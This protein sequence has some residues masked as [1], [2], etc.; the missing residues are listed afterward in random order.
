MSNLRIRFNYTGTAKSAWAIDNLSTPGANFPISYSWSGTI[1]SSTSGFPVT[2]TPQTT[3]TSYYTLQTTIAGCPGGQVQ[4]P[5]VVNPLPTFG[6][7]SQAPVCDGTNATFNLTGLTPSIPSTIKYSI[8]PGDTVTVIVS[9]V[10][11]NGNG[12]FTA[13]LTYADNGK[14]ITITSISNKAV[15]SNSLVCSV[16]PNISTT[17]TVLPL[18]TGTVA[19]ATAVCQND[20]SPNITFTGTGTGPFIFTYSINSGNPIT[21]S[22][23]NSLIL[24]VSTAIAGTFNYTLISVK[25]NTAQGCINTQTSSAIVT[26]NAKATVT[27]VADQLACPEGTISFTESATSSVAPTYTWQVSTD[28]G[29]SWNT[30]L[31]SDPDYSGMTTNTLTVKNITGGDTKDGYLYQANVVAS[32]ACAVPVAPAKLTIRNIW[33]GYTDQNWNNASNWSNNE[34]PSQSSCDS[35]IILNVANKPILSTGANGYVNHLKMRPGAKLT[36]TGNI[37]HIAGSITDDNMAIDATVGTIDLNGDKELYIPAQPRVMQTIAGHMFNTPYANNS[38]RLLNLNI[39]SPNNA[40]VA[41][42]SV[43]ND[44]LNITG[45]LSFGNLN[46]VTLH[47]GNNITLVSNAD[48]TARVAD[49]TSGNAANNNNTFDGWVEVERYVRIGLAGDQHPKAWEFLA[50]PTKGQ[51]TYQS[52]MENGNMASTGYGTQ[53]VSPFGSGF[54]AVPAIYPSMKYYKPGTNYDPSAPDWQ[55]IMDTKTSIFSQNGYMLFIRGDRSIPGPFDPPNQTRMRTKGEL[56]TYTQTVPTGTYQFTSVGNPYASAIDFGKVVRN[57]VDPFYTVW[58]S[59]LGG[60]YGYGAYDTYTTY[61]N[62]QTYESTD[63][64]PNVNIQSGQAFFVQTTNGAGTLT[65]NETSKTSGSNNYVFRGSAANNIQ[66]LRTNLYYLNA[67]GSTFRADGNVVQFGDKFNN[68]IDGMDGRK[69]FNSGPN[70]A[71]QKDKMYLVVERRQLPGKGDTIYMNLSGVRA[72]NYRFVFVAQGLQETGLQAFLED[73]YLNTL[74]PLNMGDTT[75][76]DFKIENVK[77]SYA[78]NRFDIVFKQAIILPPLIT[79]VEGTPKDKDIQVDW[80]VIHEKN[81][82]QYEVERSFD[83][84]QFAKVSTT[85]ALNKD[86]SSYNWNDQFVLPGTYYYRIKLVEKSGKVQ[87]SK[88][89]KVLIGNGKPLISIYP[90]PITNGIINLQFINQPAGKYGIRLMNQLGQIIVS[91][92]IVRMNGSNTE[93]IH[94]DYNLAHGVYQLQIFYP[95]GG[96]KVIKVI[97]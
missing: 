28:N 27:P 4:V 59:Y 13:P 21:S 42:I 68:R 49:I 92:Q 5:V 97:Y 60:L 95:D 37:L 20:A 58:I 18:P 79:S 17:L 41:P 1:L 90:N 9:N 45:T 26:V 96:M 30:I 78:Q 10:D 46:N 80:S 57:N 53:V 55:G 83:G 75:T 88:T 54:D 66:L 51:T 89:V 94:W 19:G 7:V 32:A 8:N 62:G 61:D 70:L 52:W 43:L 22:S 12:S 40:S 74:T 33:H 86:S 44:T 15:S 29:A 91:K 82:E 39:S 76:I 84:V 50:T 67:D 11:A 38:G 71:I 16:F 47:T 81:V 69:F 64:Q 14:K 72:Q 3:G 34:I 6:N 87:Y 85:V 23:V 63:G 31:A 65:F 35:V 93:S 2:A 77:E 48:G 73:H 56:L 25:D 24:P 36:I